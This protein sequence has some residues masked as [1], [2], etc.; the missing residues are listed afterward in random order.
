MKF[1]EFTKD[2]EEKLQNSPLELV[3][4]L[5]RQPSDIHLQKQ[6]EDWVEKEEK[7]R[8][9]VIENLKKNIELELAMEVDTDVKLEYFEEDSDTYG[10]YLHFHNI[11]YINKKKWE[12]ARELID[13]VAHELA[14]AKQ[15]QIIE[16]SYPIDPRGTI[17]LEEFENYVDPDEPFE[18]LKNSSFLN[19]LFQLLLNRKEIKT[20]INVYGRVYHEQGVEKVA[21]DYAASKLDRIFPK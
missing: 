6:F 12:D 7:E 8:E 2:F 19:K 4:K 11:V 20:K 16:S 18:E 3:K 14:H 13:T 1:E 17:W 10:M 15:W 9:T 21:R 5:K